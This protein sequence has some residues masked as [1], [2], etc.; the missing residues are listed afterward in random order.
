MTV[1]VWLVVFLL[2]AGGLLAGVPRA[3][4]PD[5]RTYQKSHPP[6]R[7]QLIGT[8]PMES[9]V[10]FD[11]VLRLRHR[12][13]SRYLQG[14][15]DPN[16]P[17]Y[18]RYVDPATFGR[19]FGLTPR[20]LAGLNNRLRAA[21]FRVIR[22]YPQR[23]SMRVQGTAA[24]VKR[25]FGVT[26]GV[27][28]DSEGRRYRAPDHTPRVP[29]S[30][31][32]W[33]EAVAGLDRQPRASSDY[34]PDQALRP[35]DAR[36]AYNVTPLYRRRADGRGQ[37]IGVLS[38]DRFSNAH[39]QAFARQ[40]GLPLGPRMGNPVVVSKA[41][42]RDFVES[43]MDIEI[44]RSIAPR[45][46][47]ID[48]QL[49][50]ADLPDAINKVVADGQVTIVSG[51][52]GE[53]DGTKFDRTHFGL[54]VE[55]GFAKDVEQALRAAAAKGVSFFFS[56]GDAGAYDCQRFAKRDT[57][58]TVHFPADAPYTIA[59]GGTVLSLGN[60]SSYKTET[61]W[62][63][64]GSNGGGGGGLNPYDRK[65]PWQPNLVPRLSNGKRQLPDVSAAAGSDSPWWVFDGASPNGWEK[66]GGTSAATP[67]WAASM[68]LVQQYMQRQNAGQLCFAAP[69]LY[70]IARTSWRLPPFHDVVYGGNRYYLARRGWDFAT[71][72]GSP[73]VWN[74]ATAAVVYRQQHP[75]PTT[76][77]SCRARIR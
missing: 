34:L 10:D 39:I 6:A 33:A 26:L 59:V 63:D 73:N 61:G 18:G 74:L 54:G 32:H 58:V 23:T 37:T 28:V 75:L 31:A 68:L 11:L 29:P 7:T 49:A 8:T 67:M 35:S 44:I 51:S 13:L 20:A 16:S 45:A 71:G 56:T 21:G 76:A 41:Q 55:P 12:V 48:Y 2:G 38:I 69:L 19:R 47:I 60:N 36:L 53:C 17:L 14:L 42:L 66:V 43:D 52:F 72:W 46:R 3:G 70:G 65:P 77:N 50:Y 9:R 40:F 22:G 57:H 24:A 5:S 25:A 4:T 1:R 15:Y 30:L 62:Q 27:Y 64:S